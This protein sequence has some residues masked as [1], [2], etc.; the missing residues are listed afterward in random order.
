[1]SKYC[2]DSNFFITAKNDYYS[3]KIFPCFWDWLERAA[4]QGIIKSHISVFYEITDGKDELSEWIKKNKK[5]IFQE[6]DDK[7][8]Q[9]Y[10]D[11]VN[12]INDNYAQQFHKDEFLNKADPYLIAFAKAYNLIVVTHESLIRE[13]NLNANGQVK[14]KVKI[15]NI[16]NYFKVNYV[17]TF[18]M[19]QNT[20][21]NVD[22]LCNHL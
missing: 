18:E 16:C 3:F 5:L 8:M 12:Y 10:S 7:I 22:M 14:N 21:V 11:I 6:S 9:I 20:I 1:M 13:Q 2:L 17:N 15:P 4:E 19:L